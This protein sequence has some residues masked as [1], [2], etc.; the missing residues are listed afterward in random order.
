MIAAIILSGGSGTRMGSDIPKQYLEVSG[1]PIIAYSI[2]TI[3]KS[4]DVDKILI[5]CAEEYREL[6]GK[7]MT[8]SPKFAGFASSGETRQ[9]S[10]LSGLNALKE[11]LGDDDG[12][13]I[14][15]A[16][17]PLVSGETIKKIAEELK[18]CD[19]VLP[20]LPMKDTVYEVENGM[21]VS[22]LERSRIAAGQA[23]EGFRFGPYLKANEDLLPDAIMKISGSMQPAV[24]AGMKIKTIPGDEN[25]FKITTPAD[26]TRFEEVT[27]G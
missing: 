6:I 9:L 10:V 12:V 11:V 26:L 13:I 1:K 4:S 15:D 27:C 23:P 20:V 7:I 19:A 8:G 22:N 25:N 5:V 18:Y 3:E 17:R 2:E 24:M 16:A 21:V 14:H